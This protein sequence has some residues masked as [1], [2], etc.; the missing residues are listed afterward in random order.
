MAIEYT[1]TGEF[2][3]KELL[4]FKT[5]PQL[6]E[7]ARIMGVRF[8][9]SPRKQQLVDAMEKIMTE[10]PERVVSS[11]FYYE[12]KA[13]LDVME[14][15]MTL[16]YAERS[17]LLFELNR[18]GVIYSVVKEFK[19]ITKLLF[20]N[21]MA[22]VLRP[23]IPAEMKR[24]EEDGSLIAEKL[25]LGCANLYGF[26]DI[27]YIMKYMRELEKYLGRRI[28][29]REL[30]RMLYPFLNVVG[31]GKG[32]FDN[33][34]MSPFAAYNGFDIRKD[35][36]VVW[37]E[38][39]KQFDFETILGYGE[40]PYPV[41][42][43]KANAKLKNVLEKFGKPG[44]T[45]EESIRTLWILKQDGAINGEWLSD[46]NAFVTCQSIEELQKNL[47]AFVDFLNAVPYWRLRGNSSEEITRK[48][49]AQMQLV[50]PMP[51]IGFGTNN[52]P[53][54]GGKIGRN[55]PCPCGSGK[56]YKQCC[57]KNR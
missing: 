5:I 21:E 44:T 37:A 33:P 8:P 24:R 31:N 9:G 17:G 50:D 25:I 46:I 30:E 6:K 45:P 10:E 53:S 54:I 1:F 14:G 32:D 43:T 42:S 47:P 49:M 41:I 56:K 4:T 12:L 34:F 2:T 55:D 40:M 7:M 48:K 15:R 35:D 39:P 51:P 36:S 20:C 11:M 27:L 29:D 18:F 22:E 3:L 38:K 23:L 52:F 13:C 19:N 26:T 57:G 28:D 16:E